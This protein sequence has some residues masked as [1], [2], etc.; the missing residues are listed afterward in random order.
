MSLHLTAEKNKVN[1]TEGEPYQDTAET[2]CNQANGHV[3]CRNTSLTSTD[4]TYSTSTR[5]SEHNKHVSGFVLI[6][7]LR[8]ILDTVLPKKRT[9]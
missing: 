2:K 6:L 8:C 5:P 4:S 7:S 1:Q 3:G 9:C